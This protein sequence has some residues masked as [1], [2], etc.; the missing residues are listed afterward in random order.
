M[1]YVFA[2]CFEKQDRRI[3]TRPFPKKRFYYHELWESAK[4]SEAFHVIREEAQKDGYEPFV[5]TMVE[6]PYD[7]EL[8]IHAVVDGSWKIGDHVH[9][10]VHNTARCERE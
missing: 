6:S 8:I 10:R 5:V 1:K 7:E 9:Y 3:K 2:E 4:F